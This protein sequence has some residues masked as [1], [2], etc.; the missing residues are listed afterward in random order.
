M[1]SLLSGTRPDNPTRGMD[2]L[3][4][5]KREPCDRLG[6]LRGEPTNIDHFRSVYPNRSEAGAG[7]IYCAGSEFRGVRRRVCPINPHCR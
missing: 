2:E 4:L 5:P 3:D 6:G 1:D 7:L